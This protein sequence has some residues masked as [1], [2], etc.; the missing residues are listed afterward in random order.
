MFLLVL[1]H[2]PVSKG[3]LQ[4]IKTSVAT[5]YKIS[6]TVRNQSL[7]AVFF[8]GGE[9]FA[10]CDFLYQIRSNFPILKA[11]GIIEFALLSHSRILRLFKSS[12]AKTCIW[13]CGDTVRLERRGCGDDGDGDGGGSGGVDLLHSAV[14]RGGS[15]DMCLQVRQVFFFTGNSS[16]AT[17]CRVL[18]RSGWRNYVKS[19]TWISLL[20]GDTCVRWSYVCSKICF[21]HIE[22][23]FFKW[24]VEMIHDCGDWKI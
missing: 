3:F 20:A 24:G 1:L 4:Q 6:Q 7:L 8:W 5:L 10:T 14:W 18:K 2:H 15:T 9:A 17:F 11:S 21:S 12:L 16:Q 22:S 19:W 23:I 13:P